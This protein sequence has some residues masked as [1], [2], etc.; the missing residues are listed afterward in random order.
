MTDQ[1]TTAQTVTVT[2]RDRDAEPA[3]GSGLTNPA[4]RAV[5]IAASC[6]ECDGPRGEPR[7]QNSCEDGAHYWVQ[8]WDNP[9]G[10]VDTYAAVVAEARALELATAS[11][12]V[13]WTDK[14]ATL[15]QRDCPAAPGAG[16]APDRDILGAIPAVLTTARWRHDGP[17]LRLCLQCRPLGA[18]TARLDTALAAL[19]VPGTP[20]PAAAELE[21][22]QAQLCA[23]VRKS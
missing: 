4:V 22:L 21:L 14:T 6:P 17:A 20:R 10:H 8:V 12:T 3:W 9:C 13:T 15:H 23:A 16:P 5:T 18:D 1:S 11:R 7:G 19:H 2:V